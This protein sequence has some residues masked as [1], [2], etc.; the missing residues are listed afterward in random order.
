[1]TTD[2]AI[3]DLFSATA[4]ADP[5]PT[6]AQLRRLGVVQD[7]RNRMWVVTRHADVL[8]RAPPA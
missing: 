8:D 3:P 4:L 2:T 6:Y 7:E 5:H 1:M